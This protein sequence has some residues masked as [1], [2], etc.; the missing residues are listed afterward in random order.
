MIYLDIRE[1]EQ[2]TPRDAP[3]PPQTGGD[4][5]EDLKPSERSTGD[6]T[7]SQGQ[8]CQEVTGATVPTQTELAALWER[9]AP[10]PVELVEVAEPAAPM[11]PGPT[12]P[13]DAKL[14]LIDEKMRACSP[15]EC[16]KWTWEGGPQWFDATEY[17]PPGAKEEG[18]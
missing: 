2:A 13:D 8:S 1:G 11:L 17:P 5:A 9:T 18:E 15:A 4:D 3:E 12:P 10:P 14:H 16:Y 7:A 6:S